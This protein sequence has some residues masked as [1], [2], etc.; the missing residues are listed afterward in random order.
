MSKNPPADL[1]QTTQRLDFAVGVVSLLAAAYLA[2]GLT[3]YGWAV[4]A[5]VGAVLSFLSAKY[6]PAKWLFRRLL[7]ARTR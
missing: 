1:F 5:V 4:F 2:F 6:Q 7:L 3:A